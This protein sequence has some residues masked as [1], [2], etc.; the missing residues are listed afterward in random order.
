MEH[1][2]EEF[3]FGTFLEFNKLEEKEHDNFEN[4]LEFKQLFEI[5]IPTTSKPQETKTWVPDFKHRISK[6]VEQLIEP[7]QYYCSLYNI[8][9]PTFEYEQQH[10]SS[11]Y[12]NPF[13]DYQDIA[14]EYNKVMIDFLD[15]YHDTIE[16]RIKDTYRWKRNKKAGWIIYKIH[17]SQFDKIN[18]P[19]KIAEIIVVVIYKRHFVLH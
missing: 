5:P 10:Y 18:D 16:M 15:P 17:W 19:W 7:L 8:P 9:A 4:G 3:E 14:W 2:Y 11:R 6:R 13:N 1:F 12:N